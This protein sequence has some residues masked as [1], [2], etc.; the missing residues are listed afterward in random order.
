MKILNVHLAYG[1]SFGLPG[2]SGEAALPFRVLDKHATVLA[3]AAVLAGQQRQVKLED[4]ADE[5]YVRLSWPSGQTQTQQVT[6]SP[7]GV[8]DVV[9]SEAKSTT[10]EWSAWAAPRLGRTRTAGL[11]GSPPS[12]VLL[13]RYAKV[14]LRF[15][16]IGTDGWEFARIEPDMQYKSDQ[17]RQL[18]LVLDGKPHLLQ[19]G[20]EDVPW[21]FVSLPSGGPCR[22]F[23]TPNVT[24]DPRSGPLR[25]LVT[26]SRQGAEMLMEF[27]ARDSMRA[28]SA[29]ADS[30]AL[31]LKLF[32]EK[33]EDPVAAIAGAYFLLRTDGWE[34]V[35]LGWWSN[36]S[37]SFNL[38]DA[39]ILHC[40][41]L[42]RGGL[43]KPMD[44]AKAI[45]LFRTSLDRGWPVYA[46]GLQLL[47]EASALLRN[48]A[49]P[50]DILYLSAVDALSTAAAWAGSSLSFYGLHPAKPSA[51]LW[52]GMPGE[53]VRAQPGVGRDE[54]V[55]AL[56]WQEP[57][58][59]VGGTFS[60]SNILTAVRR[61]S[62]TS[63]LSDLQTPAVLQEQALT[64]DGL[65][66]FRPGMYAARNNATPVGVNKEFPATGGELF[67]LGDIGT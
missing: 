37:T 14:W 32:H 45:S 40:L 42:L 39:A 43:A 44:Q 62:S 24:R 54:A 49:A 53:A 20:G 8:A 30:Q 1:P 38:P 60:A 10:G 25:V 58:I 31:A 36:L 57:V 15:W 21:Q 22:V 12:E 35:P 3:E 17:A 28:A 66:G 52:K 59:S 5:V 29:I 48:I 27:M 47:Q 23:I 63:F 67:F 55:G 16:T 50:K 9:F 46:E 34:K 26:S 13:D 4:S 61:M 7:D 65:P 56:D 2:K 11:D 64:S 18:D 41:R 51:V 33:F 19:I 6:F